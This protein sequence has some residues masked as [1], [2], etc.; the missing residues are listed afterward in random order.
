MQDLWLQNLD[1]DETVPPGLLHSWTSYCQELPKLTTIRIP[2]WTGVTRHAAALELHGFS[3]ASQRAYSVVVYLRVLHSPS[4]VAVAL[5][6]AKTKV[7]PLKTISIPRLELNGMVLLVRLL[8]YVQRTLQYD[9]ISIHG[10]TDSTVALAWIS[11]HPSRWP[12]YV[13]NRV[14]TIQTMMPS[15][16]WHHLPSQSNPADCASQGIPME[17]LLHHPLWWSGPP[18]LLKSSVY[19]PN[20]RPEYEGNAVSLYEAGNSEP[21]AAVVSHASS[22]KETWDVHEHFSNW[23]KLLRVTAYV[24]RFVRKLCIRTNKIDHATTDFAA[25]DIENARVF[26]IKQIQRACFEKEIEALQNQT[27]IPRSSAL[28]SLNP[29]LAANGVLRLGGR[30]RHLFLSYDERFP[31]LLPRH[32]LNELIIDQTHLRSLH[33]GTQL[34][35]RI[36]QQNYWIV[37]ARSL[38]KR[39]INQCLSCVRERAVTASQLMGDLPP[40]E[41]E[42]V[43]SVRSLRSRLRGAYASH[44]VCR[45]RTEGQKILFQFLFVWSRARCIWNTSTI[46]LLPGF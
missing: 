5:L 24:Q 30:L 44:S 35:L 3:D 33:G 25:S 43:P 17:E 11:Q 22:V 16:K 41:S 21:K 46:T 28:K 32:H 8:N 40:P 20:A 6:A 2:R 38:V 45:Q 23:G 27:A 18:W 15:I 7:A 4:K 26:W 19:W 31:I 36:L 9:T 37:G 12:T 10:W 1:W 39:R 42:S 13:A 34:T 14:S 29:F